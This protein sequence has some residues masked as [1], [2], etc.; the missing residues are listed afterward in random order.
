MI[1][2]FKRGLEA[3]VCTWKGWEAFKRFILWCVIT[4]NLR[5]MARTI[6]ARLAR[7]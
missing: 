5:V 6:I 3:S 1:S 4:F 7:A 2:N